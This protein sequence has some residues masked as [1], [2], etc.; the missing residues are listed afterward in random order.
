MNYKVYVLESAFETIALVK[1]RKRK[2]IREFI[3][4]L[5][6]NPFNQGDFSEVDSIGRT[7][8]T[9]IIHNHAIVFVADHAVE[10]VK[11]IEVL[12]ADE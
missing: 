9:K 5:S 3:R 7:I 12:R 10:E 2:E 6:T 1:S 11:V 4:S 8:F